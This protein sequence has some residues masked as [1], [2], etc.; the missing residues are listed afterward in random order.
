MCLPFCGVNT[1]LY[2]FLILMF[3][4]SRCKL[5]DLLVMSVA[6]LTLMFGPIHC[7]FNS[8]AFEVTHIFCHLCTRYCTA[9][10]FFYAFSELLCLER[11]LIVLWLFILVV[12]YL[13]IYLSLF[14]RTFVDNRIY[15]LT[16]LSCI[17]MFNN[18]LIIII[19]IENPLLINL[20]ISLI[21]LKNF[22]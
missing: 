12:Y 14:N 3:G 20:F 5:V 13:F 21:Q 17:N 7:K 16:N 22:H 18:K 6:H 19:I 4:C 8:W 11:F 9:Q 10:N 1:F 15:F 2:I